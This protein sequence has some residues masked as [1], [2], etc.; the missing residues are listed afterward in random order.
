MKN[1]LY[2][3]SYAFKK[4]EDVI[5]KAKI[6]CKKSRSTITDHFIQVGK[7][8]QIGSNTAREIIDHKLTRYA[9][10]LIAMNGDAR[11]AVI[12][13]AQT[14]FAIQTRKQELSEKEYVLLTEDEKRFYQRNLTKKAIILL[15]K[16]QKMQELKILINFIIQDIEAYIMVKLLMI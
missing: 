14:Y 12:A 15:I 10:Y 3:I 2:L 5:E 9:C 4:F 7:M 16:Q 6:A 8:V 13:Q 11:K 1:Y